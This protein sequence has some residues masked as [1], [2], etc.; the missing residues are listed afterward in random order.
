ML[1]VESLQ[2]AY[3][4]RVVVAGLSFSVEPGRALGLIG[5]NGAG[6]TTVLRALSGVIPIQVGSIFWENIPLHILPPEQRARWIAVVPQGASLPEAFTGEEVVAFGRTPYLSWLSALSSTDRLQIEQ[7]MI[8][9]ET[10]AFS[11]RRV[12]TLSGGERQRLLIA[13]AFAQTPRILLLDEAFAHLDLKYQLRL[14]QLIRRMLQTDRM[15]G[16]L[17]IHDLHLAARFCDQLLLLKNG[18]ALAFGPPEEVLQPAL[19]EAAYEIPM[20][21]ERHPE[22]GWL[23][24]PA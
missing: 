22:A 14:L 7:A 12:G 13:R 1:R 17:A 23:I 3:G 15:A 24:W 2:I 6:K 18:R 4:D 9:T 16:V 21:V 20:R 8:R 5:P 19:L 10:Q 11:E